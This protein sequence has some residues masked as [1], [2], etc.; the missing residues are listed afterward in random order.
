MDAEV[1]ATLWI[2]KEVLTDAGKGLH[3][4]SMRKVHIIVTGNIR[5]RHIVQHQLIR[6][7]TSISQNKL[8]KICVNCQ[9]S[10]ETKSWQLYPE[11]HSGKVP[12]IDFQ[13]TK[14]HSQRV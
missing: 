7:L 5:C 2:Q 10:L 6:A 8:S 1:G 12:L 9:A 3:Q 14:A 13:Q 4:L 11:R